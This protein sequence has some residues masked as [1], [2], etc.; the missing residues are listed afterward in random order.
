MY[1]CVCV[2]VC[3]VCGVCVCV[4]AC[5]RA[6]VRVR[7]CMR[8]YTCACVYVCTYACTCAHLSNYLC[9]F[10]KGYSTQ[11]CLIVMLER[12]EKALDKQH[13]AGALLTD[14]SKAFDCLNHELLIA[15]LEAYGFDYSSL[16]LVYS[17]LSERKQRT[18]I[19][20]SF[21]KWVDITTG[22]PQGSILGPL[23]FNIYL[24]D[25]F[26]SVKEDNLT[27]YADD[28][29]PYA[30]NSTTDAIIGCLVEDTTKL[31]KW[32]DDNYFKMNADKCHLLITNH[33]M[34]Y[35]RLS[36]VKL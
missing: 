8:V 13:L 2:C 32:F 4:R 17:Y 19:N 15:K 11:Y 34:T 20:N 23:L 6:C 31:L 25:I 16:A 12:W 7:A 28:N 36:V 24:N 18:K 5:V 22:I 33:E 10:R 35:Q 9:G 30:I 14:L 26:F 21:S 27:N 3:G 29:T 1:V